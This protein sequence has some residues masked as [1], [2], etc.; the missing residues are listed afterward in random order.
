[1]ENKLIGI[2]MKIVTIMLIVTILPIG[3]ISFISYRSSSNMMTD[4]YRELGITIGTEIT[5]G[6]SI[7]M[8][9]PY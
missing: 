2:R 6:I 7:K 4:Q 3:L 5:D 1:M 8:V 9:I